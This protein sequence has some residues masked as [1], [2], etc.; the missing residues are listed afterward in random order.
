MC[1]NLIYA[2]HSCLSHV[3]SAW[4]AGIHAFLHLEL[5]A[6]PWESG[7]SERG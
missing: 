5:G 4:R 7:A 6:V 2:Q 1:V 3:A